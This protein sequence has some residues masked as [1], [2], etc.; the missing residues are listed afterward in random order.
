MNLSSYIKRFEARNENGRLSYANGDPRMLDVNQRRVI[1]S[2]VTTAVRAATNLEDHE[3]VG[4]EDLR[5]YLDILPEIAFNAARKAGHGNPANY[6]SSVRTFLR[7]VEGIERK[8][9]RRVRPESFLPAWRPLAEALW[10]HKTE[11]ERFRRYIAWL[12]RFQH[13]LVLNGLRT[14]EEV[15]DYDTAVRFCVAAKLDDAQRGDTFGAYRKARELAARADLPPLEK[16]PHA[17]NRGVKSLPNLLELVTAG[18][19]RLTQEARSENL[20]APETKPP[21]HIGNCDPLDLVEFLAPQL[22]RAA[23]AYVV[24]N[25]SAEIK[26]QDWLEQI[27]HAVSASVAELVRLGV[28]PFTID[29]VDLFLVRRVAPKP[30]TKTAHAVR[31]LRRLTE[32]AAATTQSLSLARLLVDA[33]AARSYEHSPICVTAEQE[34]EAVPY[35]TN[36]LWNQLSALWSIAECIYA[37]ELAMDPGANGEWAAAEIEYQTIR[38]HMRMVNESRHATGQKDKSLITLT[39]GEA[40]CVGLRHMWLE[41]HGLRTAWHL[42]STKAENAFGREKALASPTVRAARALYLKRVRKY[43]LLALILDDGMRIKNYAQG[44]FGKNIVPFFGVGD[45]GATT[46]V[47]LRTRF[48]GYDAAAST[49]KKRRSGGKENMRT[50]LVLQSIVDMRLVTDYVFEARVDDLVHL[51]LVADR[52]SYDMAADRFAFFVSPMSTRKS[53]GYSHPQISRRFGQ[54]VHWISRDLL[55]HTDPDGNPIPTWAELRGSGPDSKVL[56]RKWRSLWSAHIVRQL[57]A[58]FIG[59]IMDQWPEACS[60][61]ND[62]RSTLEDFYVEFEGMVAE[63]LTK[64]GMQNPTHFKAICA[65]LLA[66]EIIDWQRFDPAKP[67]TTAVPITNPTVVVHPADRKPRRRRGAGLSIQEAA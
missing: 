12:E 35:Y 63:A 4:D 49:K 61:T 13:I 15:P 24:H 48:S 19:V 8:T 55:G 34:M 16:P 28:D 1:V 53:G 45:G 56:R 46:V 58:V 9:K 2:H 39:W 43:V 67:D 62:H 25:T 64:K 33:G 31:G 3:D 30:A 20:K 52:A 18:A 21:E 42:A 11:G 10:D 6:A 59:H 47:G 37:G 32:A 54:L 26:S 65:R 29:V 44:R 41:C 17:S 23:R 50:R 38:K 5:P 36:A 14:P 57:I 51:G 40:V 7:A 60:R 66:N 22:A 27:V